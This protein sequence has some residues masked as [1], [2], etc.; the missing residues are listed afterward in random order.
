MEKKPPQKETVQRILAAARDAFAEQG[1][2][3]TTVDAIARNA[4]VNKATLYYH[5]GDKETL[6]AEVVRTVLESNLDVLQQNIRAAKTPEERLRRY[7][8]TVAS[9]V[10]GNPWLPRIMLREMAAGGGSLPDAVLQSLGRLLNTL[11][12][13][14]DEGVKKGCFTETNPFLLHMM[15]LGGLIFYKTSAPLRARAPR[16]ALKVMKGREPAFSEIAAEVEELI[17]KAVQKGGN[18]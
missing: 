10:E 13:I 16:L 11:G 17:V 1:F 18:R 6:Y 2:S 8:R 7:L 15:A 4:G 14:L 3:G 9:V 12:E 5:I